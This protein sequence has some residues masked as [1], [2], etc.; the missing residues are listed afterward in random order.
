MEKV[1]Y[2]KHLAVYILGF[3]LYLISNHFSPTNLA[4]PGLDF[5]VLIIWVISIFVCLRALFINKQVSKKTRAAIIIIHVSGILLMLIL[6]S[7]PTE[8][9]GRLAF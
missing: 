7:Q 9:G 6:L 4:G 1:K 5:L 3:P 2:L 8:V